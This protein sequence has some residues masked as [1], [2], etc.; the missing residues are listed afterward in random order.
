[1]GHLQGG[2]EIVYHQGNRYQPQGTKQKRKKQLQNAARAVA[3][4]TPPMHRNCGLRKRSRTLSK[5]RWR[6][7]AWGSTLT[8]LSSPL[9]PSLVLTLAEPSR[10]RGQRGPAES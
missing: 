7:K 3:E 1:M 2:D 5:G 6:R 9:R 8:L 10:F 4:E